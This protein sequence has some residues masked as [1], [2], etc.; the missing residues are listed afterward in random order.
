MEKWVEIDG[1]NGKYLISNFGRMKSIGGKFSTKHPDGYITDGSVDVV[2]YRVVTMRKPGKRA[3]KRIHSLVANAFLVRPLGSECIN[4]I[5][6]NKMNNHVD[7]LEWTTLR[8]NCMHAIRI[9]MIHHL[10]GERHPMSKLCESQVLKM[11]ELRASGMTY[12]ELGKAFG[13]S[14]RQASDVVRGVNWGWL[15]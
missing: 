6:G 13:V 1:W 9:G 7:N 10:K 4:H 15:K 14:R 12:S 5:D 11:R 2:G 8:E 3:Q